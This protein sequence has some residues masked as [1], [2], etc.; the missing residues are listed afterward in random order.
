ME[1]FIL[2]LGQSLLYPNFAKP[3]HISDPRYIQMV[4]DSVKNRIPIAIASAFE[5]TR[6][7]E[8]RTGEELNFVH[9]IVGYGIPTVV[10]RNPDSSVVIFLEG[11][12]KAKLGKVIYRNVPYIVCEA[13]ELADNNNI[14]DKHMGRFL[15]A[16]RIMVQWVKSHVHEISARDQFLN[17]VKTPEQVI[18]CYA[19]YLV[20]DHDLQ[21]VLLEENDINQKIEIINRIIASGELVA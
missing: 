14:S 10:T 5:Q 4:E 8:F 11:K 6:T 7:Y 20:K 12:G 19:S 16:H 1:L 15:L 9:Q 13:E 2:P 3:Y 18:G 17:Y 21:Q